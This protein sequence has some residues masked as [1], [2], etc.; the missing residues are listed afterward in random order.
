MFAVYLGVHETTVKPYY[1]G[2]LEDLGLKRKYLLISDIARLDGV[3]VKYVSDIMGIKMSCSC[4]FVPK[5]VEG[6]I[7][8][9]PNGK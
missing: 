5:K 8:I 9:Q 2:Y 4:D 7:N 3:T 6:I 1:E